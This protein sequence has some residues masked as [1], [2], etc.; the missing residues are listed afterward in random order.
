MSFGIA[1]GDVLQVGS[2]A[3][4]LYRD[5]Y[6]VAR[7]APQE[8]QLLVAEMSTMS[9]S[10]AMLQ[11][12]T[13]D[14]ESSLWQSGEGRVQLVTGMLDSI[15]KTLQSLEKYAQK[16]DIPSSRSA[17]KM[18]IRQKVR[19]FKWSLHRKSIEELRSKL[20]QQNGLLTLLLTSAGNSSLQRIQ[21]TTTAL[22]TDVQAIRDYLTTQQGGREILTP[23]LSAV[24]DE[25][26]RSSISAIL[27]QKAEES[28]PWTTVGVTRWID[29]GRWW[30]QGCEIELYLINDSDSPVPTS[31]YASLLKASWILVDIIACHPQVTFISAK[32]RAEIT[33]LCAAIKQD[34]EHIQSLGL[35]VPDITKFQEKDLQIWESQIR[36][37]TLRRYNNPLSAGAN[38]GNFWSAEGEE[39]TFFVQRAAC[40]IR[41]RAAPTIC[42]VLFLVHQTK[43]NAR[44]VANAQ[45]DPAV[46]DI[47]FTERVRIDCR[48]AS[49]LVNDE[50]IFLRRREDSC[51][52]ASLVEAVNFYIHERKHKY[53]SLDALR[54]YL[55]L[56]VV[57]NKT[58]SLTEGLDP[59][60]VLKLKVDEDP[61]AQ[62]VVSTAS[63]VAH[64]FKEGVLNEPYYPGH[65]H[66]SQHMCL[67]SWAI[68]I[69]HEKL[70]T[71]LLKE[72]AEYIQEPWNFCTPL[73]IAARCGHEPIT[74]LLVANAAAKGTLEQDISARR[75]DNY[76]PL[77][78]A[79]SF[80]NEKMVRL[81]LRSKADINA[82][83]HG[84]RTPL[85]C[86]AD[87]NRPDVVQLLLDKGAQTEKTDEHGLTALLLASREGNEEALEVL[88]D[89]DVNVLAEDHAGAT[90][91][92]FA[93][94]F[95]HVHHQELFS[96][97]K[98][99]Y[100][101]LFIRYWEQKGFPQRL[102][103]EHCETVIYEVNSDWAIL[104]LDS[105]HARFDYPQPLPENVKDH[106]NRILRIS[107][108]PG[109]DQ[110]FVF[111]F[112]F[113][114]VHKHETLDF[115]TAHGSLG[116]HG[117][118]S[119]TLKIE[120]GG[121][122]TSS[123]T[124]EGRN[125]RRH[126]HVG[127]SLEKTDI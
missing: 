49:V 89:E 29:T 121:T 18:Q 93:M 83:G 63:L 64:E 15:Y 45:N 32:T 116:T 77:H 100:N 42:D 125:F 86:A 55:T 112:S 65:E 21:N 34:F 43:H 79:C 72:E 16:Y 105:P 109:A 51:L 80:G 123:T 73:M 52:L 61:L 33:T 17:S 6:K 5:C 95:P 4:K 103:T 26:L 106:H 92:H 57:K 23:S 13:K 24:D 30:L 96:R 8:F 19:N 87:H 54:A 48:A 66:E 58:T 99:M 68:Q 22:E 69:G 46:I 110:F 98:R 40:K 78:D 56:V 82:E 117:Y 127:T 113:R 76:S 108:P 41:S 74:Q 53:H 10:L 20:H 111:S 47:H 36:A 62:T 11:E 104:F 126:F 37:P 115:A 67:L 70:V 107:T 3:W 97:S 1:I 50:E 88:L 12:E 75:Y 31:I 27:L 94:D 35:K 59:D 14:T 102:E 38:S 71:L 2:L 39:A 9:N 90:V 122:F 7:D 85:I 25:T 60:V 84:G 91:L 120:N 81:Y 124:H 119:S 101:H 118:G 114:I 44:I 28:Q